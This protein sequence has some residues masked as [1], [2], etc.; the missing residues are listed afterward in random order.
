MYCRACALRLGR[1]QA[2]GARIGG[3]AAR[4]APGVFLPGGGGIGRAPGFQQPTPLPE[5]IEAGRAVDGLKLT[6]AAAGDSFA[7]GDRIG[8]T[9]TFENVSEKPFRL[10]THA[11]HWYCIRWRVTGNAM[12]AAR[13]IEICL[14][15][16]TMD[17]F[18]EMKPGDKK[19]FEFAFA[20]ERPHMTCG[21]TTTMLNGAGEFGMTVIYTG[22]PGAVNGTPVANVWTGQVASNELK[23][24]L[25]DKE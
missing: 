9:L 4:P 13:M 11:L 17:N 18:P 10:N 2:C 3:G 21:R 23:L 5:G 20:G 19:T 12:Q 14:A 7:R 25:K 6:L 15:A 1:C 16:P 24:T 22:K 8:L